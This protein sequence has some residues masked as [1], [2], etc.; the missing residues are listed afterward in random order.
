MSRMEPAE[1][2][3]R[4]G[5]LIQ[6]GEGCWEWQGQRKPAGYGY[7]DLCED[8]DGTRHRFYVHRAALGFPKGV[9]RH[10]C[11]NPSCVRPEHLRTGTQRDNADDMV[12]ANRSTAVFRAEHVPAIRLA[13]SWGASVGF[14]ARFAGV[15]E[16]SVR[17]VLRGRSFQSLDGP[18]RADASKGEAHVSSR[19]TEFGVRL[20]REAAAIGVPQVRIAEAFGVTPQAINNVGPRKTWRHVQ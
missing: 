5:H 17:R 11:H 16:S 13:F 3:V 4:F 2:W 6:R 14:L 8:G 9:V 12:R 10:L 19:L 18:T 15:S 7:V 20:I 1:F